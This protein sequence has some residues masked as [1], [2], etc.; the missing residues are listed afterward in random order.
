MDMD[1]DPHAS[2]PAGIGMASAA[3]QRAEQLVHRLRR[4]MLIANDAVIADIESNAHQ[5]TDS[6]GRTWWDIR[7]MLDPREH[8]PQSI[9]MTAMAIDYAIDSGLAQRHPFARHLV[10]LTYRNR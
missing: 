5:H 6:D 1:N 2:A 7:P 10:R 3:T 4:A 9:D 8:A